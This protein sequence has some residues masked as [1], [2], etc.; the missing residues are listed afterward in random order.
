[1][2]IRVILAIRESTSAK[3]NIRV[4]PGR[5]L[6][7]R[8]G[9]IAERKSSESSLAGEGRPETRPGKRD[10]APGSEPCPCRAIQAV[11]RRPRA[12]RLRD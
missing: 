5:S 9:R 11:K 8:E 10:R 7:K 6:W 12:S 2:F 1:M 3:E 4:A